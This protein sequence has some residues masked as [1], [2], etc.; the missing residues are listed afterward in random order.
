[1]EEM[2]NLLEVMAKLRDPEKG[3][4]WDIKQTFQSIAPYTIEEAYEVA[5]AIERGDHA[6]L[7]DELGDL[8]LQVVF[9]AQMADDQGLFNFADVAAGIADKMIHRHPHVFGDLAFESEEQQRAHWEQLKQEE[10]AS[11][12]NQVDSVSAID[13]VALALPALT[14]AEKIQKRAAR[15]GFDWD[16]VAPVIDKIDEELAEFRE[17]IDEEYTSAIEDELGDLLFA[18]TNAARHLKIDP[19]QA[20]KKATAKFERRFRYVE[21]KVKKDGHVLADLSAEVLDQYWVQ[22]KNFD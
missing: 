2:R 9:H 12:S 16:Q 19:E 11:K 17:A 3:C 21:S 6:D 14:R 18:A 1:M 15:V 10:R 20:L 4:E 13:D 22:A 7:R 5:D 8:L